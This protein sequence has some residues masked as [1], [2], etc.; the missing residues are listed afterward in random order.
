MTESTFV[1][2]IL[3]RERERER[4]REFIFHIAKTLEQV[5]NRNAKLGGL[6]ERHLAHRARQLHP[7][8]FL[9]V[10]LPRYIPAA[11]RHL[12]SGFWKKMPNRKAL[13][14]GRTDHFSTKNFDRQSRSRVNSF[15]IV[16]YVQL[17]NR[18]PWRWD[19]GLG[20]FVVCR[21]ARA[22]PAVAKA[23]VIAVTT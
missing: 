23:P 22:I 20:K 12:Y 3:L 15:W 19:V 16:C 6:P 2:D 18:P 4:E 8:R 17:R 21:Y 13:T 5:L 14:G 10:K 9:S 11:N 7:L 1:I